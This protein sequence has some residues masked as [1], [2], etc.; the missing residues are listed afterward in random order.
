MT[1]TLEWQAA[2][3]PFQNTHI[4]GNLR[5][6]N[7]TQLLSKAKLV[8]SSLVLL[9]CDYTHGCSVCLSLHRYPCRSSPGKMHA[10]ER[11]SLWM[12]PNLERSS[13]L[14]DSKYNKSIGF[15]YLMSIVKCKYYR[16]KNGE[17]RDHQKSFD[18]RWCLRVVP[19]GVNKWE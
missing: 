10:C 6:P 2:F 12:D 18:W 19:N 11:L 4:V 3:R 15:S 17:Q 16:N 9:H 5:K 14:T 8:C 1:A 13:L 7:M